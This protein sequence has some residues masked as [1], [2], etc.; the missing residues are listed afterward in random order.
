M[1]TFATK[2]TH[3][4][5]KNHYIEPD[6]AEWFQYG[7]VRRM[8]GCLTFF[9]L[10][11]VGAVLVGWVGS[12]LYLYT[13]RFLRVRTGGYHS[14]TTYGCLFTSL[15]TM[16]IALTLAKVIQVPLL[17]SIVLFCT[18]LLILILGPVNN[19]SLHLTTTEVAA[20]RPRI[21]LRLIT[22]VLIGF[23]LLY[24]HAP[25]GFCIVVS[26]LAVAIMLLL[27]NLGFGVQ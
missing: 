15:C 19:A 8:M 24:T 14:K 12:F 4:F 18:A 7:L 2:L 10:L 13:F 5:L 26:Q 16:F 11:P 21:W 23:L 1:E 22:T 20:I 3:L 9:L 25:L 6:Q 17:G 27:A